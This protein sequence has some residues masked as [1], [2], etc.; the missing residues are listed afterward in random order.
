MAQ[1]VGPV[2]RAI[3]RWVEWFQRRV[4]V[5]AGGDSRPPFFAIA[6]TN[7]SLNVLTANY[8]VIRGELEALLASHAALPAY[9]EIDPRQRLISNADTK[10]WKVF[11]L[12]AMGLK[13]EAN[14]ARCPETAALLDR[15]SNLNQAFFS[16]LEAGKSVPAH[17]GPNFAQL[18]YHLGVI[19]P[20]QNPP[21][22]RVKDTLYTWKEGEAV[23]FDDTW[24]HEVI[25]HATEDRVVLIV[26]T[27]R[28]LPLPLHLMNVGYV[29]VIARIAYARQVVAIVEKFKG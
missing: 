28:P 6:D 13:P 8:S 25:N 19:V 10:K 17:D 12:Y 15:V 21:S 23:M 26:D 22:L 11:M 3:A 24:N 14:R 9:H 1:T 29:K 27:M 4:Y 20:K 2:W 5:A 18:R 7:P 16:I